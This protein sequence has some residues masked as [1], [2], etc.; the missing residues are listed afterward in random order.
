MA[1]HYVFLIHGMGEHKKGEWHLPWVK[2]LTELSARYAG[3]AK[4]PLD[5]WVEFVP[6]SYDALIEARLTKWGKDAA[7]LE[8]KLGALGSGAESVFAWLKTAS[9]EEKEFFWSHVADVVLW[10]LFAQ[11]RASIEANVLLQVAKSL[12]TMY[13]ESGAHASTIIAHSLGTAVAHN[14]VHQLA[15]SG[16]TKQGFGPNEHRWHNLF[17]I[18]N[19]SRVI[20]TMPKVYESVTRPGPDGDANSACRHFYNV[21]HELDP[22]TWPKPFDPVGWPS[23]TKI[24]IR[25]VNDWNV[26]GID[27]Y[28]DNPRVHIPLLRAITSWRLITVDEEIAAVSQFD[29]ET[30]LK[31]FDLTELSSLLPINPEGFN[32]PLQYVRLFVDTLARLQA[33][34]AE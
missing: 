33:L 14:V 27:H 31:S 5:K 8:G 15:T 12:E 21:R 11:E 22:F 30:S 34:A 1:K 32:E 13:G 18:A 10:T 19:V 2:Q 20:Q 17:T 9:D 28:F 4:T 24:A 6:I 26:H 25:Q 16:A 7:K 29:D 3:F 23:F